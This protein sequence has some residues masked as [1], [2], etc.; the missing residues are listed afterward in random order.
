MSETGNGSPIIDVSAEEIKT[1]E[2]SSKKRGV[3]QHGAWGKKG[4]M[5][6]PRKNVIFRRFEETVGREALQTALA[7]VDDDR[8]SM[9]VDMMCDPY[10][11]KQTLASLAKKCGLTLNEVRDLFRKANLDQALMKM[12]KHV[13]EI[14]EDTAIDAKSSTKTCWKCN[15]G[16]VN[17]EGDD[18]LECNGSGQVRVVGDK[19]ARGYVFDIAGLSRKGG[20]LIAQQFNVSGGS[21]ESLETLIESGQKLL[22][23]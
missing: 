14:L 6:A 16:R 22:K 17:A 19:D 20:P 9:L 1:V 4:K 7:Q 10:Y 15:G 11:Q 13:P 3:G 18:C 12:Y 8:A 2:T 5:I 23:P 21:M